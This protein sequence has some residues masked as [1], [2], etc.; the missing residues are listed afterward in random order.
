MSVINIAASGTAMAN[1]FGKNA[2]PQS[3][4]AAIGEKFERF[5]NS[6]PALRPVTSRKVTTA[7][8]RRNEAMTME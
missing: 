4:T 2:A 6:V 7:R 8:I 3:T 5:E 1:F